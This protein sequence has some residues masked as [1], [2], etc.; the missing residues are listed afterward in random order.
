MAIDDWKKAEAEAM[1][2][3]DIDLV[4][5]A[6]EAARAFVVLWREGDSRRYRG[7][8]RL[9]VGI[10]QDRIGILVEGYRRKPL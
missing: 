10:L 9:E 2:L 5:R 3:S 6:Q 7:D 8:F 4:K 1:E